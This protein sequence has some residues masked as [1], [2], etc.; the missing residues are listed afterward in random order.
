M[1]VLSNTIKL[2]DYMSPALRHICT[3]VN[4]TISTFEHMHRTMGTD[5]NVASM[6]SARNEIA[7]AT[8]YLD[9]YDRQVQETINNTNR[10]GNRST[11]VFDRMTRSLGNY[12]T[13]YGLAMAGKWILNTSDEMAQLNARVNMIN[14]T[15]YQTS[16]LNKLIFNT[17]Q[18]ARGPYSDMAKVIA[19][20]RMNAGDAFSSTLEAVKFAEMINKQFKIS[21]ATLE[22]TN[23]ATL[24]L[25]QALG[26]GV[27]RG[28]ELNSVFEA[29]PSILQSIAD[30]LDV[31]IGKIRQMAKEGQITADVIKN[32]MLDPST[33]NK[34][35]EQFSEIPLTWQDLWTRAVNNVKW[36]LMDTSTMLNEMANSESMLAFVDNLSNMTYALATGLA[37]A[38]QGI[39]TVANFAYENWSMLAP[40]LTTVLTLMAL[41]KGELLILKGLE[42]AHALRTNAVVIAKQ[43]WAVATT[44]QTDAQLAL[45]TALYSCPLTWYVAMIAL[46]IGAFFLLIA[47]INKVTGAN[48]SA[49]GV[50]CGAWYAAGAVIKNIFIGILNIAS[51]VGIW[52]INVF[53]GATTTV[54]NLFI[55]LYNIWV[56]CTNGIGQRATNAGNW[57]AEKIA[58]GVNVAI[59]AINGLI[60]AMNMIPGVNIGTVG[61]V[62][63]KRISFSGS[64]HKSLKTPNFL[65]TNVLPFENISD[66]YKNGYS[67]GSAWA[68]SIFGKDKNSSKVDKNLQALMDQMGKD[69]GTL[70]NTSGAGGG[71]PGKHIKDTAD[72]TAKIV[73]ELKA[74]GENIEYLRDL[75]E[76]EVINRFT[77][78]EIKINMTNNN[79]ISN[80]MDI[81]GV[82]R[83][84]TDGVVEAMNTSAEG[85]HIA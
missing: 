77:T 18:D 50:I 27:L 39:A 43:L 36:G 16:E 63:P 54:Q 11:S 69:D 70:G 52:I 17:A 34:I 65:S 7:Q 82:V 41:Y 84:L 22:E 66:A 49:V 24:Q 8:V 10:L 61:H 12:I 51:V 79:S 5:I 3:A 38:I 80:D 57:I 25:T 44:G 56:D 4:Q 59:D 75:A 47:V 14:D 72:N 20:V 45:N 6:R 68:D 29:A 30:Y 32:A 2:N 23:A 62:S 74:T 48:I 15:L 35:N 37:M 83:K 9:N 53:I 67:I 55:G 46:V 1:A 58:R 40:I 64:S 76:R 28:D 78:A 71:N 73:E 85:V 33:M 42:M 81:D 21:G 31:P 60:G 19:R 26:S 13:T